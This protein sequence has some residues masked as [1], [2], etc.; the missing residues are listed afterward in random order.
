MPSAL[1]AI[2]ADLKYFSRAVRSRSPR[3]VAM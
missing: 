1:A 3:V 2:L